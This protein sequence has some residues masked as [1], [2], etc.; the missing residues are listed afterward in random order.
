M[1]SNQTKE[2]FVKN[3]E[4]VANFHALGDAIRKYFGNNP[5]VISA[6][7][8]NSA[9][10]TGNSFDY[11]QKQVG[12]PAVGV[13][14]FDFHLPYYKK[15]LKDKG[16]SDSIDS[17]V[18]YVYDNI[19]GDKQNIMGA[20]NAQKL[21]DEFNKKD[22]VAVSDAFQNIFLRPGKPHQDRRRDISQRIFSRI[23]TVFQK[24][25]DTKRPEDTERQ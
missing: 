8:G 7:L 11:Q 10:E 23:H 2:Q 3:R 25:D 1:A 4:Q 22:V 5:Y 21:R 6:M 17:Q 12:G 14:Q 15:Y 20:G 9:V 13:F 18:R 24:E 19:Y 16:L